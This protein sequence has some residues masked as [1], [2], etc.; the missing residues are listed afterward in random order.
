MK[1]FEAVTSQ[2]IKSGYKVC[3]DH[4]LC[5]KTIEGTVA[6]LC[7]G[8]GSGIYANIAATCA[9]HRFAEHFNHGVSIRLA[10]EMVAESM[11]K[12]RS[13]QFPFAAFVVATILN[14]GSFEVY[15]YEAP[16]AL[17]LSRGFAHL[18]QPTFFA[19]GFE[20]V[21]EVTGTLEIGDSLILS[22]DGVTQAGMGRGRGLGV[23]SEGVARFANRQLSEGCEVVDLPQRITSYCAELSAGKFED[24]TTCSLLLCRPA[25][26]LNIFS[27]PPSTKSKD[28]ECVNDFLSSPGEKIVCGSTTIDILARE[29]GREVQKIQPS[30]AS[31][32][33]PP[34]YAIEGVAMATEGAIMLNQV[35][36]ILG[37]TRDDDDDGDDK[38]VVSRFCELL[39][40]ADVIHFYIG[41]AVNEAHQALIFKQMGL[42]PRRRVIELM[43]NRLRKMGKLVTERRY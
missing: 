15:N 19:A 30:T 12:A 20:A 22:S 17:L 33:S 32:A 16:A 27:G 38:G 26:E 18:L 36:N 29:M 25:V 8:V 6:I 23:G 37:E 28:K 5:I 24:D 35:F 10:A 2:H 7:D 9:V 40:N 4:F 31:Y 14:D 3:G 43:Q 21:G 1:F 13:Q 34:E 42:M 11:H 39:S 41:E